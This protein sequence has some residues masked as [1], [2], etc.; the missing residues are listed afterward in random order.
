MKW[1]VISPSVLSRVE[2]EAV[3]SKNIYKSLFKTIYKEFDNYYLVSSKEEIGLKKLKKIESRILSLEINSSQQILAIKV[4]KVE[5]NEVFKTKHYTT[6][7][8]LF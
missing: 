2:Q 7:R 3:G 4:E 5:E 6:K 8:M 1:V